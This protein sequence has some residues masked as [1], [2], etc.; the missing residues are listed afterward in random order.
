[1]VYHKEYR[2]VQEIIACGQGRG[3]K[4]TLICPICGYSSRVR[5]EDSHGEFNPKTHNS[6]IY[7]PKHRIKLQSL[8]TKTRMPRKKSKRFKK[9]VQAKSHEL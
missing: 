2:G 3:L 6:S 7:C 8:G 5:F 9:F 1:M 4:Q